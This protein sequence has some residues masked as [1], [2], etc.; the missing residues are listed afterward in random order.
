MHY[1]GG[2]EFVGLGKTVGNQHVPKAIHEHSCNHGEA[3]RNFHQRLLQLRDNRHSTRDRPFAK[4]LHWDWMLIY[5]YYSSQIFRNTNREHRIVLIRRWNSNVFQLILYKMVRI[6]I[7]NIKVKIWNLY[8][9]MEIKEF[10]E[11]Y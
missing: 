4:R 7:W 8:Q 10:I 11:K 9:K 1:A 2:K 3:E 5:G 6:K